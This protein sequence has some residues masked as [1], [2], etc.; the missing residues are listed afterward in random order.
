[1]NQRKDATVQPNS[2]GQGA[3]SSLAR[4]DVQTKVPGRK[5]D[6]FS[7]KRQ[8]RRKMQ[9][10][11]C[12][13]AGCDSEP[14]CAFGKALVELYHAAGPPLVAHSLCA[15]LTGFQAD[16]ADD[17]DETV[18]TARPSRGRRH[19]F[20]HIVAAILDNVAL[21]QCARVEI[22]RQRSSSRSARIKADAEVPV[23]I[24]GGGFRSSGFDGGVT[25]PSAIS[26]RIC[27]S[28]GSVSARQQVS[29]ITAAACDPYPLAV[30]RRAAGRCSDSPSI[31]APRS[32]AHGH[33]RSALSNAPRQNR[34]AI[35][36][37]MNESYCLPA[38]RFQRLS[39]RGR[40][41]CGGLFRARDV[42]YAIRQREQCRRWTSPPFSGRTWRAAAG[43]RTSRRRSCGI[44]ASLHRTEIS[45][46]ERGPAR[47]PHRHAWSSSPA[48]LGVSADELL[49]G[50][51]WSPGST[52]IGQFMLAPKTQASRTSGGAN[53]F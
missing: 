30:A 42:D 52:T 15:K 22:E 48:A 9:S 28:A 33:C 27:A 34:P 3:Q 13:Q 47:G 20:P 29:D 10:V 25:L 12:A 38:D 32:L 43:A 5:D 31:P 53:R 40:S 44:R 36:S 4:S 7:W 24:G 41:D 2:S 8:C 23:L 26:F 39:L 46:L 45:Q 49:E 21:D 17:L 51:D 18:P 1:M 19:C 11:E 6:A 35:S 16:R 50:I 14:R 37:T